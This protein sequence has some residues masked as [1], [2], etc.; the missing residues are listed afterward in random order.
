M[1]TNW[2]TFKLIE[3]Y[4]ISSGLSKSADE[5][6]FGFPFLSF[7]TVFKN[8]FIPETLDQLVNTSIKEQT[9]CSI[10]KGDVF[11]TRTSEV[12]EELG[13]SCVSLKDYPNATFNGF[14]KRL[15]P[16]NNEEVDPLFIGYY[17]RNIQFRAEISAYSTLTTRASLNNGIIE[18]L[19]V[20]LPSL[21]IQQ[22]IASILSSYDELIENN[23]QRIKLLEEMAEEIY[24]EWFVRLRFSGY[25][26]T[27]N[28]DGLPLGWE[29][30]PIDEFLSFSMS[31]AKLKKF[32]STK[33]YIA[34]A[35][36]T[37]IN[38]TGQGEIIDWENKPSRA[39]LVP[40]LNSVFF[41]RMSNTYKVLVFSKTN[42]E[43]IDELALTSGFLGLKALNEETLPYL[44][45]LIKSDSF[46]NYKDVFA[47]G[48]TQV[49]LTNEGF[50]NIKLVEPSL[51]VI[52]KFGKS[53]SAFL[54]EIITLNKKNQVLQETRDLL[55]PRL[56][57]GKLRI[58]HLVEEELAMV[59]EPRAEYK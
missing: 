23:K 43:L 44:F 51:S 14:T 29:R 18:K 20:T 4:D 30:K 54:S 5:F 36:V 9:T 45:W 55:L 56:I 33:T 37:D 35:D 59:A 49:S 1:L 34:T 8:Y 32:N 17:L 16:K 7:S 38:I 11:L 48:A 46:H 3:L 21:T 58:E 12:I 39:Q 57:S 26:N 31:K 42:K 15:R 24:K 10:K 53:T 2:K 25:E 19:K 6:G 22:K 27:K 13:M 47:N 52:E 50:H 28:L 41:A 40:E